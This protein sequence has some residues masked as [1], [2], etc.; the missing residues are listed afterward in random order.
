MNDFLTCIE[1]SNVMICVLATD[2]CIFMVILF[3]C[4]LQT[5]QLFWEKATYKQML[6]TQKRFD[7]S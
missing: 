4:L 7:L 3:S 6:I 2:C 1:L 5:P